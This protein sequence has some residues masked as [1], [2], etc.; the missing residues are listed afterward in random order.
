MRY[1]NP[2]TLDGTIAVPPSKSLMQRA[3]AAAFLSPQTTEIVNASSCD[4]ARHAL[5]L[6]EDLGAEVRRAGPD[7]SGDRVLI[8]GGAAPER[9]RVQCG[10][11]GL[12]L[13]MFTPILSLFKGPIVLEA[14]GSLVRRPVDMMERP[15]ADLGAPCETNGGRPPVTV[16]GPLRGGRAEVDGSV[17]SQFLSGLLLA[18]PLAG[19]RSEIVVKNLRSR[20]YLEMTLAVIRAFGGVVERS[21]DLSAFRIPG[22]QA[23]RAREFRVEGDWS[24]AA[25][26]L[27]AGALAGRVEISGL[28]PDSLQPDRAVL[29]ALEAAGAKIRV[30]E[31]RILAER[32]DLRPFSFDI[33]ECPDLFPPLAALAARCEGTSTIRGIERLLHKE[34]ARDSAIREEFSKIGVRV[35]ISDGAARIRGGPIRGGQAESHGDHRIAMALALAGLVS[36]SGVGISGSSCV[37]KSYPDFFEDL[38]RLGGR[39]T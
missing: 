34:S 30:S 24:G 10:E 31:E 12:C 7:L 27:T 19:E 38:G 29:Q 8:R 18:L 15:L 35:D 25:V 4:D 33:G 3:T 16:R 9:G 1:V 39:I 22:R 28:S 23:Y 26:L 6:I 14:Q 32:A 2:S 20:S 36:E 13:R 37:A 5:R 17:S 11:S 21:P